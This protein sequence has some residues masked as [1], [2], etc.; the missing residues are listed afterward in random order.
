MR[1]TGLLVAMALCGC[2]G[3]GG[4]SSDAQPDAFVSACP[5]LTGTD[6]FAVRMAGTALLVK[7]NA[8]QFDQPRQL[9][10]S[11]DLFFPQGRTAGAQVFASRK[12]FGLQVTSAV[13]A[14]DGSAGPLRMGASEQVVGFQID[15][16]LEPAPGG[17]LA[18]VG[19]ETGFNDVS[20][21][22]QGRMELCGSGEPPA[23]TLAV[24]PQR[25]S[26]LSQ[27]RI[28]PTTPLDPATLAT[29]RATAGGTES[30]V[31]VDFEDS[32]QVL[33]SPVTAFP[34]DLQ[35]T[36]DL[37][38]V[39]DV[40][41][42]STGGSAVTFDA[43]PSAEVVDLTFA[44]PLPPGSAVTGGGAVVATANG[45]LE[46][47][48]DFWSGATI[49]LGARTGTTAVIRYKVVC[50]NLTVPL[51]RVAIVAVDGSFAELPLSCGGDFVEARLP[52]P[53]AGRRWLAIALQHLWPGAP[54]PDLG[55]V[56]IDEIRFE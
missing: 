46:L 28:V 14:A 51:Q 20:E 18:Q 4:A 39:R 45:L 30:A 27:I 38:G 29:I 36:L 25:W 35:V 34:P 1:L 8:G 22:Y 37:T 31:R 33:V 6:P 32:D 24:Q 43:P 48:L 12:A 23:P 47:R 54:R 42:R 41:G 16:V 3:G 10:F 40:M 5:P 44:A 49:A 13:I 15:G 56:I 21:F 55:E 50:T 2:G 17:V 52:V 11:V 53:A 19:V 26:P 7:R 9:P